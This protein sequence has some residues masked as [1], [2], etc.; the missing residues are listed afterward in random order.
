LRCASQNSELEVDDA[1]VVNGIF[2]KR[3]AREI[4]GV[5]NARLA[6]VLEAEQQMVSGEGRKALIRR[7]GI[8]RGI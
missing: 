3:H 1:A 4:G 7:V 8:A 5:E 2:G 6:Q